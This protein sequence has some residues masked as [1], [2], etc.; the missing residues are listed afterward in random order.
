MDNEI[1]TVD[2]VG[3]D[4]YAQQTKDVIAMRNA[5]FNFDRKDPNAARK[6]IQNIT[7]LRVYHQLERIVRYTEVIDK[8]ED[9]IYQSIDMK[10]ENSEP[11]DDSL[12]FTLI[13]IQ[14]RLQKMMVES[15][16]LLEPY[17]SMEQLATFEVPVQQEDPSNAFTSMI[18]NQESREKVRTSAQQLL[19]AIDSLENAS[20]N[21]IAAVQ[22]K[23]A[24]ALA[25]L[26]K[27]GDAD[28]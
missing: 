23:A 15:H 25:Q 27:E 13:P 9:R 24:Q 14:E 22:D 21:E 8:L 1:K 28:A 26:D 16:K 4:L 2:S 19:S 7:I 18:L 10:L 12:W 3:T 17:L 5:L 6:A 11:D 20:P